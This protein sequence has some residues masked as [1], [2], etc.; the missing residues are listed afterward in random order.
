MGAIYACSN[1]AA[2]DLNSE[3]ARSIIVGGRSQPGVFDGRA[4][5]FIARC[6]GEA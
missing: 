2:Q 5:R 4:G 3:S 1:E 6:Q